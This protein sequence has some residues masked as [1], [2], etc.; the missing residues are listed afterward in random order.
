MVQSKRLIKSIFTVSFFTGLSRVFGLIRDMLLSRII[1]I[2]FVADVFII[3]LRFANI[4][5]RITAEG[6]FSAAFVPLFF[7]EREKSKKDSIKFSE[8]ILY[9]LLISLTLVT[10]LTQV[11]MPLIIYFFAGGFNKDPSKLDLAITFSRLTLPYIIFI[12]LSSLGS[13]ILN[14]KGKYSITSVSPILLNI[15][16][17]LALIIP[18]EDLINKGYLL[19]L[20]V[21]VSGVFHFA[22]IFYFLGQEGY[23]LKLRKPKEKSSLNKFS[24]LA[25][26]QIISGIFLQLN[27][28]VS[29]L[30]ASF[31]NGGI[32]IL[33]YA[34]RLYQLPLALIGISIGT[35]ILP[36]LSSLNIKNQM[37]EFEIVVNDALKF[38]LMLIIPATASFIILSSLMVE[39]IYQYGVFGN[40]GTKVVAT[41]LIGFSIG[42]PAYVLIKILSSVFYSLSD[43][44]TPLIYNIVAIVTNISL[45]IPLFLYSGVVGIAYATSI[46][47]W[48]NAIMLIVR[49]HFI[50][51]KIFKK[52][53]SINIIK[54][55]TSTILM[56]F[57]LIFTIDRIYILGPIIAL[58]LLI[59]IGLCVYFA[60]LFL[61]GVYKKS[62][63]TRLGF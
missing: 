25:W 18:Q 46:S 19:S 4:F 53:F 37:N 17:I 11:F 60:G 42:L 9:Y 63:I 6:A 58:I 62:D 34:E 33:Y 13:A 5:R 52:E 21:S 29:G 54:I 20:A 49:L 48:L 28:V 61:M 45:S 23:T 2:S 16:L 12:S 31:F 14:A 47:A 22:V 56:S 26:P 36:M 1:G 10:I 27:I 51:I 15:F 32:S 24:K 43:T 8:D 40:E 39:S 44:R 30:I 35:V 41:T 55:I 3:A 50:S 7:S 38:S 57:I 59:I